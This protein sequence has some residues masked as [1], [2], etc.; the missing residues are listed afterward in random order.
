MPGRGS[1]RLSSRRTT[2][3]R[4]TWLR[5]ASDDRSSVSA[6]GASPADAGSVEDLSAGPRPVEPVGGPVTSGAG[7]NQR[8]REAIQGYLF[9]SPSVIGFLVFILGP[10]VAVVYLS[11]TR[12]DVL[13][14][15][16]WAGLANY[17]RLWSDHRLHQVYLN[18]IIYVIAAVIL[19]NGFALV[20]AVII[21]SAKL[22]R[23]ITTLFRS[24]YFFPSLISLVYISLIWQALFQTD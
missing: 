22:P 7:G 9:V 21:N 17:D 6:G 18:T 13:T 2:R 11:F 10:L 15:P 19:I 1:R 16:R 4:R 23:I 3:S 14:P 8:R 12:Y 24:V 5:M 20:L